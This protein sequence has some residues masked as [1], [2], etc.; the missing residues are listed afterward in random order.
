[1]PRV[2]TDTE[3]VDGA[4]TPEVNATANNVTVNGEKPKRQRRP[5]PEGVTLGA[6]TAPVAVEAPPASLGRTSGRGRTVDQRTVTAIDTVK[7]TPGQWFH[8]G[9]YMS[10]QNPTDKQVLGQQGF[11]FRNIRNE[12]G[13]YDRYAMLP[14]AEGEPTG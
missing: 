11:E 4:G 3:T 5:A 8:I 14:V 12:Q 7:A 1:M 6:L 2:R 10:P 9:T 13:A